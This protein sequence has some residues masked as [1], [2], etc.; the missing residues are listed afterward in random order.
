[1]LAYLHYPGSD[2]HQV[3]RIEFA[4]DEI[5]RRPRTEAYF[6]SEE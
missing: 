6:E 3:D 5:N 2:W 4:D 1:M